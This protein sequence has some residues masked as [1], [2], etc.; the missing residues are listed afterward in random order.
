MSCLKMGQ[1]C[2]QNNLLLLLTPHITALSSDYRIRDV[3]VLGF[4]LYLF[5]SVLLCFV[6]SFS[7]AVVINNVLIIY[8]N[9]HVT[10]L[11]SEDEK[12][13]D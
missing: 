6:A 9:F 8:T 4:C 13:D 12:F 1:F 3:C 5:P 7:Q 11:R 2:L 10:H